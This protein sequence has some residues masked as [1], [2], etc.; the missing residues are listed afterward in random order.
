[1]GLKPG[2]LAAAIQ[3][4]LRIPNLSHRVSQVSRQ[5]TCHRPRR[6]ACMCGH[7]ALVV[8]WIP[9]SKGPLLGSGRPPDDGMP[10]LSWQYLL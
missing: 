5:R 4:P 1:M 2:P 6:G 9:G 3:G 8:D 10:A 7:S